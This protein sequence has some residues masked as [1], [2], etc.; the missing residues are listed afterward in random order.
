M[1]GAQPASTGVAWSDQTGQTG[2]VVEMLAGTSDHVVG[3]SMMTVLECITIATWGSIT[4]R[5]EGRGKEGRGF[6]VS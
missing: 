2:G 6:H 5:Y 1:S 4:I 3:S